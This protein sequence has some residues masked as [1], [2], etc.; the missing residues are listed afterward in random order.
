LDAV[1]PNNWYAIEIV[2]NE[3]IHARLIYSKKRKF[4]QKIIG[5]PPFVQTVGPWILDTNAKKVNA[6][7]REKELLNELINQLPAGMNVDLT[8]DSNRQYILPFRWKGF[9]YEPTF[10]YRIED[11]TDLNKIYSEF[12]DNIKR[13]IRKAEKKLIIQEDLPIEVLIEFQN[14][15]FGR[16]KRKNPLDINALIR[17][18]KACREHQASKLLAAKDSAGNIHAVTYFVYDSKRCY[19]MFGGADP[20][21]KNSGAGCFLL[22]EGIKFASKHSQSFD[23]EG[24]NI[25]SIEKVFRSF[26]GEFVVNYRVFKLNILL[27]FIDYLKPKIKKIIGYKH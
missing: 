18:D 15:T 26:S 22:W 1:A 7:S 6:L 13:N 14:K 10:S 2:R 11:L 12:R 24:S 8:L 17:L 5:N 21:F 9:R 19:Y 4:G 25:E 27:F 23:F 16:Q 3:Q 20:E